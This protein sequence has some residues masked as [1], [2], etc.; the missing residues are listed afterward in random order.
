M[1]HT[2]F[3]DGAQREYAKFEARKTA[4][5]ELETGGI[6]AGQWVGAP[7][8][9]ASE[10]YAKDGDTIA[11]LK[12][13]GAAWPDLR[14]LMIDAE[15]TSKNGHAVSRHPEVTAMTAE[16]YA[17]S[18]YAWRA[19]RSKESLQAL[20]DGHGIDA[21]ELNPHRNAAG[22]FDDRVDAYGRY[23]GLIYGGG[24]CFNAAMVEQGMAEIYLYEEGR[25]HEPSM[26]LKD[27]Y[28]YVG[29]SEDTLAVVGGGPV[30]MA[31]DAGLM[32]A[33]MA[34]ALMGGGCRWGVRADGTVWFCEASTAE[35]VAFESP[36]ETGVSWGMSDIGLV[37]ELTFEGGEL[38]LPLTK[39]YAREASVRRYGSASGRLVHYGLNAEQDVDRLAAALLD[40]LAYPS[41]TGDVVFHRGKGDVHPGELIEIRGAPFRRYHEALSGE[42][43]GRYAGRL[44]GAVASVTHRFTGRRVRTTATLTSPGRAVENPLRFIVRSQPSEAEMYAFRLDD[45]VVG[46]DM[47]YHLD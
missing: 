13:D 16:E 2:A 25:Y 5:N 38:A 46:L 22:A 23:V 11:G 12:V 17:A 35:H 37:N 26:A 27:Y 32:E 8:L 33:L 21:V 41:L 19:Q 43:G 7:R 44:V 1:A 42:W 31:V 18:A 6:S 39:T 36:S 4:G 15:E 40:D 30:S 14:L 29:P 9:D 28:S 20:I 24:L 10:A 34:L 3:P 45:E 47:S